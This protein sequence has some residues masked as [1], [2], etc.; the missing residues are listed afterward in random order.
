MESRTEA[1][2]T[3]RK[4]QKKNRHMTGGKSML[5]W[6]DC[7]LHFSQTDKLYLSTFAAEVSMLNFNK[8][9]TTSS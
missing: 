7:V 2:G 1:V 5:A 3:G 4:G 8:A 6:I 9:S